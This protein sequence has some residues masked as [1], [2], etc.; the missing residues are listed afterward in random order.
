AIKREDP[1]G[2][3]V[4]GH[5]LAGLRALFLA[6]ERTDPPTLEWAERTLGV[7]VVDHWWQTETGWAITATPLG[8]ERLPIKPGSAGVPVPGM[9]VHA[10]GADG[11]P[12]ARNRT[13]ALAIE[14]PLP[15]GTFL[16]LWRADAQ[17][18]AGYY[19]AYPGY[20]NCA[21]AGHI[22]DD[23]Y[24]HVMSRTDDVIN[25]AGHRLSTGAMEEVLASHPD[26]AECAVCG[27]ADELKGEVP[28]GFL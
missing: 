25:V 14:L 20:Y 23:G 10:L 19:D 27:V 17:A 15:P 9:R 1:E 7:P 3:H 28:L 8:I 5:D 24:V 16:G 4:A 11:R 13:G 18:R 12:V 21:D 26:V 2:S 22:D 6:G